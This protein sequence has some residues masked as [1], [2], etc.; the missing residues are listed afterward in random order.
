MTDKWINKLLKEH[1]KYKDVPFRI[2]NEAKEKNLSD[3]YD[4]D[5]VPCFYINESKVHEGIASYNIIKN[6]F[7]N[8][9]N[10]N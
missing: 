7:E 5:L 8:A 4:Y 2:I 9:Y 10:R 1:P 6:V 3:K